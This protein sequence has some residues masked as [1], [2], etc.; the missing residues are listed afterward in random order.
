MKRR[1]FLAGLGAGIG[2]YS[3]AVRVDGFEAPAETPPGAADIDRF[4]RIAPAGPKLDFEAGEPH[5][6]RVR[7]ECDVFVAGGGM[8]GVC[9][10]VA[11]ARNGAKVVLVQDRSRLGGNAS[12]E[13]KMHIV[14]AS[15]H[16]SRL[17]WRESGLLEEFR[18]DD[19]TNNPQ[20]SWELWDLLLYDK[21]MSEPNLTLLLDSSVTAAE[22]KDGRIARVR[23]R[24]DKTEH[25]YD[26]TAHTYLD[27]TGDGR[28]A[29]E[30]GASFREGRETREEFDEPL[31]PE[32]PDREMLGSSILFTARDYGK[33]MPFKAPAWA[34]KVTK[35]Q[36]KHR[37]I[38][39]WEYGYWW[40][41]WGGSIDTIRDNERIRF[42]LLRIVTG[43]WD[44]IKN[45]GE[46]PTAKNWAPDWIGMI[47]GKRE[48]RRI[49]G[50]YMLTQGDLMG[51]KSFPDGIAIGGWPMDDHAKMDFDHSDIPPFRS[52]K[53]PIY[54][55]PVRSLCSKDVP[56]LMMAG[57]N[58]SCSHVA[59]TS[60]RVMGTCAVM[61][62]AAG[63]VA[64]LAARD[65]VDPRA[66]HQEPARLRALQQRLLRDDQTIVGVVNEDPNDLARSA[67]V[68]ASAEQPDTPAAAI[69]DGITRDIP[70]ADKHRWSAPL[71]PDGAWVALAWDEPKTLREVQ[72]TFDSGFQRELTLSA[73][74]GVT[75]GTIRA[76]QPE[77]AK[78]Y[79]VQVQA[80]EGGDWKT[81]AT[82][83]DNHQRLV[84]HTFDPTSARAVRLVVTATQGDKLAR[85][86]EIRCYA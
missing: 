22:V 21:V 69:L 65:K 43:I 83:T 78:A 19:A 74:D 42:E 1:D 80:T 13:V 57:R 49:V 5:M 73:S 28:L 46:F 4:A 16:K 40:V 14:G 86:F 68:T 29:V 58:A 66:F 20:R 67:H 81:V 47:P 34:R 52:I 23:V 30:A 75:N 71:G 36:L 27:C 10:A 77:T 59:F 3:L 38:T 33:P 6:V 60:T 26:V 70:G 45:S 35:E 11:A 54:N 2:T 32:S 64:A 62:Q 82:A 41:E 44:H 84:R 12:S 76:P 24:C 53:V 85:V 31:A 9:A 25:L 15:N 79:T 63:T 56:N 48:S 18:L 17:G 8:S 7:L 51:L 55:I 61:G 50:D 72:V 37:K 39:S